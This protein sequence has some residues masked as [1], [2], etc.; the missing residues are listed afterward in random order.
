[1]NKQK[2][3]N[4]AVQAGFESFE[5]YQ[6]G[7]NERSWTWFEGKIDTFVTSRV[8]STS[9]R[10]IYSGK[11][12][13]YATEDLSDDLMETIISSM[14]EQ[15]GAITADEPGIIRSPQPVTEA[16]SQRTWVRPSAAQIKELLTEIEKRVLAYDERIFMVMREGWTEET[17]TRSI[18]NSL[19]MDL[20]DAGTVQVLVC[21]AAAREGNDVKNAY[22]SEVI[23]DIAAFD[24]DAFVEKLCTEVLNKLNAAGLPSG[25]Y[26]AIFESSAMTALFTAFSSMF[27]GEL[28]AKGISPLRDKLNTPVFS[29]LITV[30]DNPR[31]PEAAV[32]YAFDDEGCPTCA[33]TIVDHGVFRTILHNS[34][35]ASRMQTESTGNGFKDAASSPV[36]V[37]PVNCCIEPGEKSLD[38]LCRDMKDGLVITDLAGLH[39]GINPVTTD[40]SLQ[41]SGYTVKDGVRERSVTL[42]TVAGNFLDLLKQTAAV[43][44]DLDWKHH[45]IVTPS[46]AF[47]GIAVSGE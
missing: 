47:K 33:K 38:E 32:A 8:L 20:A 27:S 34:Q 15:A 1:M 9:L 21:G 3:I 23:E 29:E 10:G 26:P 5:I 7:K 37:H 43:G 30:T 4:A 40:F 39:A 36:G 46:I 12:V 24:R 6:Q 18:T 19:G 35:S 11:M 14:K 25:T 17:E 28:I 22:R 44:N 13:N 42:I 41:C 2:W 16:Q 31:R 45:T